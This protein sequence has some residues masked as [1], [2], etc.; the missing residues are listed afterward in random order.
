[1]AG[2]TIARRGDMRR[3]FSGRGFAVVTRRASFSRRDLRMV[4]ARALP[5][6]HALVAGL[7]RSGCD[8]VIGGL[9]R[10]HLAIVARGARAER[11]RM[12]VRR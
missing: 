10:R 8:N 11:L 2:G 4:K 12:I 7:A 9:A 1:M 5:R 6:E 3:R